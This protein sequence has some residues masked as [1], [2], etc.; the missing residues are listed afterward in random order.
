M[1]IVSMDDSVCAT[2]AAI[3]SLTV[4][5]LRPLCAK[6]GYELRK[7]GV[8]REKH[9][10]LDTYGQPVRDCFMPHLAICASTL[11]RTWKVLKDASKLFGYEGKPFGLVWT[12]VLLLA[13]EHIVRW[14]KHEIN[15]DEMQRSIR[16]LIRPLEKSEYLNRKN[17]ENK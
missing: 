6:L 17:K 2:R 7:K 14:L 5:Q 10:T 13:L 11:A 9:Q 12:E 4:E 15:D 3:E 16:R 8:R 1:G